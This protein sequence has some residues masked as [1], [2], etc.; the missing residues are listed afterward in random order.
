MHVV[1]GGGGV[2]GLTCALT[3]LDEVPGID[4]TVIEADDRLGG[5]IL[6]TPFDG[7]PVDA[8]ADA[9]LAR[10]PDAIDLCE[11]LGLTDHMVTPAERTAYLFARGELRRFPEGGVLGIPTD[12]EALAASGVISSEG[13]E[14]AALDLTMGPDPQRDPSG[15]DGGDESVGSLVRRR[16]GD[17]V[18]EVLVG[19][20]LSGVNAGNADE[21]SVA[22]GAPQFAAAMRDHGSLIAG[23]RAQRAAAA[24]NA[25][26]PV[27]YGLDGGMGTLIDALAAEVVALGGTIERRTT[28]E[29]VHPA[30]P[31][32][33]RLEI[34]TGSP[35]SP[36]GQARGAAAD[37]RVVDA[38][39]LTTP[40]P[41]TARLL[42]PTLPD[43]A[44]DMATVE[45]ASAV[46]VTLA[47]PK[48][49]VDH[50][51]DASGFLVPHREGLLLTACSWASVKWA[52]LDRPDVAVL[53]ASA[54]RHGDERALDLDDGALVDA[55]LDDL[56]TTMGLR[57]R[58]TAIRVNRWPGALPQ[59]RPG[60][61]RR[62]AGW[63]TAMF[64]ASPGLTATGA[65]FEGL[66]IPAC[67]R[68]G[69]ATAKT[70]SQQVL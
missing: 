32:Y 60:H 36:D 30:P 9:F 29:R 1:I 47:V 17:E 5:R 42:A 43:V 14:R 62:I 46:M 35:G 22:A 28:I 41:V 44:R 18:Y 6:T 21:L 59:F 39:V 48:A 8:A 55:L 54:G 58:P 51:L 66:G 34:T 11:R 16:L 25:D 57:G 64:D 33:R 31:D 23:A 68:Q 49:Q 52:H 69:R 65:G 15:P 12:L 38:V 67:V 10:V 50:P 56:A 27:F 63:R 53:R 70:L 26:A 40:L 24:A 20:L 2:T 7:R 37:T 61:L 3:L 4:V 19:P 13:V 45:Y